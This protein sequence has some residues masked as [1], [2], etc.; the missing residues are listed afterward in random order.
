M[1]RSRKRRL[2]GK[3]S[4]KSSAARAPGA[5][6]GARGEALELEPTDATQMTESGAS[7]EGPE[8]SGAD[9]DVAP[10]EGAGSPEQETEGTP[11]PLDDGPAPGEA[12]NESK[13]PPPDVQR[14]NGHL[15][16][17]R[18]NEVEGSPRPLVDGSTSVSAEAAEAAAG[19]LQRLRSEYSTVAAALERARSERAAAEA[20]VEA[21]REQIETL[22]EEIA[23]ESALRRELLQKAGRLDERERQLIELE[24]ALADTGA[25]WQPERITELELDRDALRRQS[26]TLKDR[27]AE[28]EKEVSDLTLTLNAYDKDSARYWKQQF[29]EL[30]VAHREQSQMLLS[31]EGLDEELRQKKEILRRAEAAVTRNVQLLEHNTVLQSEVQALRAEQDEARTYQTLYE[32]SRAQCE[33]LRKEVA[34]L[35]QSDQLR[36]ER[37]ERAF[38]AFNLLLGERRYVQSLANS[39]QPWSSDAEVVTRT[40]K[41]ATEQKFQFSDAK[42]RGFLAAVRSSRLIILRGLS[43]TGKTSLPILFAYAIG[44]PCEVIPVQPSWRS[45]VD[46]LGFFNHFEQRFL[47]TQFARALFKAQLPAFANRHFFI[48]LD[49]MNLARVEYYFNDFNVKLQEQNDPLIELFEHASVDVQLPADG[50]G[51]Y[52]KQGNQM[53]IPPN[54]TFVGTINDDETTFAISDKIYDRAQ[55]I[56]FWES[57]GGGRGTLPTERKTSGPYVPLRFDEYRELWKASSPSA[58]LIRRLDDFLDLLN[59]DL[60]ERFGLNLSYRPRGQVHDFVR[61]YTMAGGNE[62]E[63]LDLQLIAKVLPKIRYSHRPDFKQELEQFGKSVED[64]WPY[65]GR[66]PTLTQEAL[67]RHLR[68]L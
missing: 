62:S 63:A 25:A 49:E 52:I 27:L 38:E 68:R 23:S 29:D 18:M 19:E 3:Q 59:V 20:R 9:V 53:R 54:V 66:R 42:I 43:G 14:T 11:L 7:E 57:T 24:A 10:M 46:L 12:A 50:V 16:H 56:D 64:L 37:G 26:Q 48:V 47:P 34:A 4:A 65:P 44:A 40:R 6:P 33:L 17:D 30:L 67:G 28:K 13:G 51:Q 15:P 35:T 22:R 2:A 32:R 8:L 5:L 60:H 39:I 31:L 36:L 58:E 21:L 61:A 41:L 1:S 55:V 45:K